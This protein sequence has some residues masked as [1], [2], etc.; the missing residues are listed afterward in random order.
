MI[1]GRIKVISTSKIKKIIVIK[2][3]RI[4]NGKREELI[5]LKPHSK[6]ED[7]SCSK[8]FFLLKIEEINIT[9]ILKI[10]IIIVVNINKKIIYIK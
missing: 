7:F 9:I 5:G 2:K 8:K 3:N 6:G 4:E 10:I 1:I